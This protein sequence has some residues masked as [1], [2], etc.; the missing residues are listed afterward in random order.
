MS[1]RKKVQQSI[2]YRVKAASTYAQSNLSV[3]S[4][5]DLILHTCTIALQAALESDG[6]RAGRAISLLRGALDI[7]AY[8]ILVADLNA[9]Y[10]H[11]EQ[12]AREERFEEL[13]PLVNFLLNAWGKCAA[14]AD[15]E[16]A[17]NVSAHALEQSV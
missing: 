8:P 14:M 17:A 6:P 9:L 16:K 15:A 5:S 4:Q 3:V 2:G 12:L 13:I 1:V 7:T 11:M 10:L